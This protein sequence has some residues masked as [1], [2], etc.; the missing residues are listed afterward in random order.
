MP[1]LAAGH[2]SYAH[3][4]FAHA[5]GFAMGN[6]NVV[7][8]RDLIVTALVVAL[9][10]TALMALSVLGEAA[11]FTSVE[12]NALRGIGMLAML[13]SAMTALSTASLTAIATS[14]VAATLVAGVVLLV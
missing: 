4:G 8:Q 13:Y 10:G 12:V 14:G 7:S 3:F 1:L 2:L 11:S 6:R 5:R 9:L